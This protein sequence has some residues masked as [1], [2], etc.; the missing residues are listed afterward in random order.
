MI[1]QDFITTAIYL[2]AAFL[3]FLLGKAVYSLVNKSKFDVRHE[4]LEQDNLAFALTLSG[5]FFGLVFAIGGVIFGPSNGLVEDLIDIFFYGIVSIVLLN[6]SIVI[7]DKLILYKFDNVK[8]IIVDRNSGTGIVE[9]ASYVA[10]GMNVSGA[11][12]GQGG[13]LITALVFWALGQVTLI[14]GGILYNLIVPFDIHDEI[15]KDN[16]AVGVAFAGVLVALGNI[17]RVGSAGD[18]I[19]WYDNLSRFGADVLLGLLLLPIVRFTIAKVML[20]GAD[21]TKEF[22][23]QE[24]PNIGLGAVEAVSFISAS[25]LIGWVL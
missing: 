7:N 4:L 5:Y 25:L 18:F 15:E 23:G 2:I 6:L 11:V 1:F 16:V 24:E 17:I 13:D 12:S 14:L 9:A 19:S 20:P 21:I 8:E 10:V 3:V 22:V